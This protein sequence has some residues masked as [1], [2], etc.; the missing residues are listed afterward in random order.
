MTPGRIFALTLAFTLSAIA[1]RAQE[2]RVERAPVETTQ[3]LAER[4]FADLHERMQ[5]LQVTLATSE[6]EQSKLLQAGN[7]FVQEQRVRESLAKIRELLA[8]ERW[9]ESLEA[10][11]GARKDLS[12]LMDL[13]LDR[14]ADLRK[15]LEEIQRLEAFRARVGE[16]LEQ[17]RAEKTDAAR[18][19]ALQ[20]QLEKLAEAQAELDELIRKQDELRGEANQAGLA[21]KPE[22]AAQMAEAEG[23]LK[24]S[25]ESTAKKLAELERKQAELGA[26]PAAKPGDS[27]PSGGSAGSSAGSCQ[28][29]S[30]AMGKAQQKLGQNKPEN[31]LQDMD[32]ALQKLR[33]AKAAIEQMTEEARRQLQELPFELQ[34]QKQETTR[35]DT[36][37]LAQDMQQSEK[38]EDG[39][40]RPRTPGRDNVQQAVPKQRS[41]AGSL[42]EYKPAKAKQEQQDAQDELEQAKKALEDALAQLRQQLQDGVL[43][44]L[45]ERFGAMLAKQ[46][47]LSARTKAADRLI[48]ESV[49]PDGQPPAALA[50]R[51]VGL[52][53]GEAELAGD[54]ADAHKLLLEE[55]STAVFPELI[56]EL[57]GDLLAVAR[58]LQEQRVGTATQGMQAE[59]EANLALLIDALRRAI[60][61]GEGGGNCN[62]NGEPALVP[63]SAELKLIQGLQ[64]RVATRT[65]KYDAEVPEALRVTDEA[66]DEAAE[67]ARKEGRIVE[68]TRALANKVSRVPEA[69]K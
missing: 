10:M 31:S 47:D 53:N 12:T 4:M 32:Q 9:D 39:S 3:Q 17:Q 36:D 42:K 63:T 26:K 60:E 68:L 46:K 18:A 34:A 2:G 56:D 45:E 59:I 52:A 15:L 19:E 58:R 8:A 20:Q 48:A 69:G 28:S 5:R 21:A 30:G 55:G 50:E 61:Q 13:L 7:R 6:P 67:I 22:A 37:K 43:R 29:A 23:A 49:T 11:K 41:A 57:R 27:A 65:K 1:P 25:A 40:E 51:C 14:S 33:E 38:A 16:L 62:C 35:I 64:K 24:Q 54:A 66:K 44:S